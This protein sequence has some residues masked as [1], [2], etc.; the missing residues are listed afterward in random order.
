MTTC[1]I[2]NKEIIGRTDKRFCSDKCRAASFYENKARLTQF[3]KKV[4]EILE[5]NRE[6]LAYL[7]PQGKITV[8]RIDLEKRNF[9]FKFFSSV[10]RTKSG[11]VYWFCYDQGYRRL[12]KNEKYLLIRW[13]DY[14]W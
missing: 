3:K 11:N 5:G 6:I 12:Q 9:N 2:C 13:Q 8:N 14:M 1:P 7:N 10:Y 4:N